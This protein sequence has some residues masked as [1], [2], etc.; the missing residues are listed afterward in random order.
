MCISGEPQR[1]TSGAH[2]LMWITYSRNALT[3]LVRTD[4]KYSIEPIHNGIERRTYNYEE[5]RNA[6]TPACRS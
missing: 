5:R 6:E 2:P 3:S 4:R 1:G